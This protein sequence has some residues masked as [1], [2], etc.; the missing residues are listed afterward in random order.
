MAALAS[1]VPTKVGVAF[2]AAAVSASDTVNASQ[3]GTLGGH[4]L[5]FNG[6]G[7]PDTVAIS[8]GGLT[9][10]G[11]AGAS[12]GSAVTNATNEAFYISPKQVD[13]AT[14]LVTITH[15]FTTSVTCLFIPI[16]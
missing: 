3:L 8:D 14:G 9:P 2:T 7:S 12:T 5:V 4:L 6:G 11:Q 1:T 16:G 15:S 10:A 13:P